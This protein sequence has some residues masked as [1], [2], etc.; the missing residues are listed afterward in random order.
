MRPSAALGGDSTKDWLVKACLR[1]LIGENGAT[2]VQFVSN[3]VN[4]TCRKAIRDSRTKEAYAR[5]IEGQNAMDRTAELE[6]RIGDAMARLKA[7]S[8]VNSK[9]SSKLNDLQTA[10]EN[11]L[12]ELDALV[13][14]LKPL[15]EEA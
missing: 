5:S 3:A 7:L 1:I 15:V 14:E 13:A 4:Y 12:A 8:G 2:L 9:L 10:R 11:D 6:A